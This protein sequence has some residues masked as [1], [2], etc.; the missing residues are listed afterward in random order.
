[1]IKSDEIIHFFF[2]LIYE[3]TE[4]HQKFAENSSKNRDSH[5]GL[6]RRIEHFDES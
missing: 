3:N 5:S 4:N 1:M 6:H 2:V